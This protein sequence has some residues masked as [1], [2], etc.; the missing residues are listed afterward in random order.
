MSNLS[1]WNSIG[2]LY[3]YT[4]YLLSACFILSYANFYREYKCTETTVPSC[5][6]KIKS[7][8]SCHGSAE[9][10]LTSIHEDEGPIPSLTQWVKD[11]VLPWAV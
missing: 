11:P 2:K 7:R 3:I 1:K 8:P 4:K 10:N 6:K 9:M 5:L